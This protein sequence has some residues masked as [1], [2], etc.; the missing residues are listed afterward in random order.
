MTARL[1]GHHQRCQETSSRHWKEPPSRTKDIC[2]LA[3]TNF[4]PE[5]ALV[6]G[7]FLHWH[8]AGVKG[9]RQ[10]YGLQS[11]V[12]S[13]TLYPLLSSPGTHE[14]PHQPSTRFLIVSHLDDRCLLILFALCFQSVSLSKA[15]FPLIFPLSLDKQHQP[16]KIR[17]PRQ[18]NTTPLVGLQL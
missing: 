5:E 14:K 2:T 8:S 18:A 16:W 1:P 13:F 3:V 4:L 10:F 17:D 11:L 15:P 6:K 9:R 7:S 12:D